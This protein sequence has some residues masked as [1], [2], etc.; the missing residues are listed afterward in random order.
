MIQKKK[1]M[2]FEREVQVFVKEQKL[3]FPIEINLFDLYF[4]VRLHETKSYIVLLNK[5]FYVNLIHL[6]FL[7]Y[8][9][10]SVQQLVSGLS[11][12]KF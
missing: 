4:I 7:T 6:F 5:C 2:F 9:S 12:L 3:Q 11:C 10:F 1:K 8:E